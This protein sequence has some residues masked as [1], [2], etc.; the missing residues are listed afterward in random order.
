[1]SEIANNGTG[2]SACCVIC[3]REIASA[4]HFCR[5]CGAELGAPKVND[6]HERLAAVEKRL[7]HA[8]LGIV[9]ILLVLGFIALQLYHFGR[10]GPLG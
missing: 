9:L 7:L 2:L 1:M 4:D 3:G 6:V 8:L 10:G 5:Y